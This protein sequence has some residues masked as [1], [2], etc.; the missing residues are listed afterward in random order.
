MLP[1]VSKTTIESTAESI[2][3]D[4]KEGLNTFIT[5]LHEEN[6]DLLQTLFRMMKEGEKVYGEEWHEGFKM[7]VL[8][9][10]ALLHRQSEADETEKLNSGKI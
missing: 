2:L 10:Y 7:G 5:I 8:T 1:V 3:K 6:P 9:L 4:W